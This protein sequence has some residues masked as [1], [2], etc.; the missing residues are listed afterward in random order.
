MDAE[1]L[2]S[3][4]TMFGDD[5][6]IRGLGEAGKFSAWNYAKARAFEM[7]AASGN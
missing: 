7:C 3:Q 1:G 4:Y 6:F 5:P 2:H